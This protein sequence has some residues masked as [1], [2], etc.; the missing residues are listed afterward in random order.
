MT[1]DGRYAEYKIGLHTSRLRGHRNQDGRV[2][3]LTGWARSPVAD[4]MTVWHL[5]ELVRRLDSIGAPDAARVEAA[6]SD[7]GHLTT[8]TVVWD[9]R[10]TLARM[11]EV[12]R[13][14]E[15]DEREPVAIDGDEGADAAEPSGAGAEAEQGAG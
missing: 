3:T 6:K 4:R 11:I 12:L 10:L 1:E 8:L 5:R 2:T 7:V 15:E 13:Q 9:E 14:I